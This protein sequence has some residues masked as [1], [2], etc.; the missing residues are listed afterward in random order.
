MAYI[1]EVLYE[2]DRL[3]NCDFMDDKGCMSETSELSLE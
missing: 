2:G 3:K 1:P